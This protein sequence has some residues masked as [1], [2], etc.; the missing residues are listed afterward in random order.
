MALTLCFKL[1]VFYINSMENPD[2]VAPM[3][4]TP[5]TQAASF[6]S[7]T[8]PPEAETG[9]PEVVTHPKSTG[10]TLRSVPG[11]PCQVSS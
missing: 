6:D 10:M 9:R 4:D 3:A 11:E 8:V 1:T 2:L 7:G 5:S